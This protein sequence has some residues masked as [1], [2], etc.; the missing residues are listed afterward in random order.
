MMKTR[1]AYFKDGKEVAR[2]K[3]LV[4]DNST[5]TPPTDEQLIDAGYEIREIEIPEP[6]P[7]VPTYEEKVV[8]LIRERYTMDDE[9]A[10]LRQRGRKAEEFDAYDAYCEE[11]K[12]K[13]KEL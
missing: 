3:S 2:P 7:Y 1:K 4:V 12:R 8:M 9:F 11:C 5:I 13:A 6:Q 10:L